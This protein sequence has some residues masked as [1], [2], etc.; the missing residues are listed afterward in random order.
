[1]GM[2][3]LP[4]TLGRC[5]G[6]AGM[7]FIAG[8]TT[9]T[10][11]NGTVEQTRHFGVVNVSVKPDIATATVVTTRGLGLAMGTRTGALGYLNEVAFIAPDA[12]KCRLMVVIR[13]LSEIK[14]L[15]AE[16]SRYPALTGL[17]FAT[18]EGVKS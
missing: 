13:D 1:M 11:H 4:A 17:C 2:T 9:V 8:C 5:A 14:D 15:E 12:T 7:A 3:C 16:L 6:A 18:P 10:V